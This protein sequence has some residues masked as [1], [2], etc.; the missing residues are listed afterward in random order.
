MIREGAPDGN[1]NA[2][3]HGAYSFRD[4]GEQALEPA[5][6]SRLAELREI[7][8]DKQ[9][10]L[11]LIQEETASCVMLFEIVQSY[12]AQEVKK[13]VPLAEIPSLKTLPAFANTMQR[14][15]ANL[16]AIMPDANHGAD[17]ELIH[18]QEVV[19]AHKDAK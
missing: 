10:L 14:S 18:I 8:Q 13:G 11:E 5:G 2:V 1:T 12:V 16:W 15:L 19:N 6:R 9:G 3:K 17:A 4:H 7:V